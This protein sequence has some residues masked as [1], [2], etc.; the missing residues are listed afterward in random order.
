MIEERARGKKKKKNAHGP[1]KQIPVVNIIVTF[2]RG[3]PVCRNSLQ[4]HRRC[5]PT[6][7][8]TVCK[9]VVAFVGSCQLHETFS[10]DNT[11]VGTV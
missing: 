7:V 4:W 5:A 8:K 2:T 11:E 1:G 9:F 6:Q 3:T 10:A